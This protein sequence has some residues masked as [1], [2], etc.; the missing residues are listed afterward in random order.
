MDLYH[1]GLSFRRR[2]NLFLCNHY[3]RYGVMLF[4]SSEVMALWPICRTI[5]GGQSLP[6]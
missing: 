2:G 6:T 5:S 1:R 4:T 3:E